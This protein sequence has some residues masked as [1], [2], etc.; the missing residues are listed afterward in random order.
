MWVL[1]FLLSMLINLHDRRKMLVVAGTFVF[2]SGLVYLAFMAAWLSVF[3]VMGY[4]RAIQVVLGGVALFVGFVNV[5]DSV[6]FGKGVSLSIPDSRKPEIYRRARK[7]LSAENLMGALL[8]VAALAIMVNLVEFL[9]TA[10]LPAVFT[11]VLANSHLPWWQYYGY[12]LLY[13]AMYM[14]DDS[15]MVLV[16]VITLSQNKLQERGGRALK[17]VSG[18]VMLV[19]AFMLIFKPEW[20]AALG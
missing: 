9:C 20:M 19:L 13:I 1:L 10:G 12:L 3:M 15:I 2:I 11:Q 17:L 4:S 7:I 14:L 8:G 16:A 18:V 6:A 5:K